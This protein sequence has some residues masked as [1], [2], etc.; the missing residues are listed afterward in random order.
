MKHRTSA[1]LA[2][3]A[4]QARGFTLMELI[5][6]LGILAVLMAIAIPLYQNYAT[7]ARITA[8]LAELSGG[9]VGAELLVT[10]GVHGPTIQDPAAVG[11][12]GPTHLCPTLRV[13]V[14]ASSRRATLFCGGG[15]FEH[16]ELIYT[17]DGGWTCETLSYK[18]RPRNNWA[19]EGCKP[20]FG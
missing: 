16:V 4:A 8:M 6:T 17:V 18:D 10:E 2:P 15:F 3:G 7:R 14:T 12:T 13:T 11:L 5:I 1:R 9:K 19:P 20:V